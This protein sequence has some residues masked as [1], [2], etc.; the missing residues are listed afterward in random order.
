MNLDKL[1]KIS[2]TDKEVDLLFVWRNNHKEY[3]RNY[4]PALLKGLI[5]LR[6]HEDNTVYHRQVFETV[7]NETVFTLYNNDEVIYKLKWLG[8]NTAEILESKYQFE[9]DEKSFKYNSSIISIYASLMAYIEYYSDKKEYVEV[10]E[11]STLSNKRQN[12]NNKKK[13]SNKKKPPI[14]I[15]RKVYKVNVSKE[16]TVLDKKRYERKAES[17][18]VKGHWRNMKSGK[19]VWVKPYVKGEGKNITPKEYRL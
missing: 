6:L 19:K 18:T 15:K 16:A 11:V 9:S 7:E 12:N 2:L 5:E 13:N 10:K 3:V 14:R 1:D 8:N 17:W 4:K